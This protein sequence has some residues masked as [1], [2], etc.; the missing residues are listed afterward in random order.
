M[1][2]RPFNTSQICRVGG[3]KLI[4]V[5]LLLL[6]CSFSRHL[7]AQAQDGSSAGTH[8]VQTG[9]PANSLTAEEKFKYALDS[10][11][12]SPLNYAYAAAGAGLSLALDTPQDSGYGE[13]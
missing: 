3:R 13:G 12:L 1:K 6:A 7:L 11:L 9:R 10:S 5:S 8:F 2:S 4:S